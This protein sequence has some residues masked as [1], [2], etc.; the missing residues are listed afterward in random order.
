MS[1]KKLRRR[2]K[3]S[4]RTTLTEMVVSEISFSEAPDKHSQESCQ[5]FD[6][7]SLTKFGATL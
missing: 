7:S 2:L 3:L 5:K 1:A 6:F 4:A